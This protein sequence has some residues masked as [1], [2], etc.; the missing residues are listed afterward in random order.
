MSITRFVQ[1]MVIPTMGQQTIIS[2]NLNP[3]KQLLYSSAIQFMYR[4][5]Y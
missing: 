3:T 4:Y 1:D 2:N 5:A